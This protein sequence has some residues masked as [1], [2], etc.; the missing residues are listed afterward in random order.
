MS[1]SSVNSRSVPS[2]EV[3][4]FGEV[5][6]RFAFVKLLGLQSTESCRASAEAYLTED[7]LVVDPSEYST[8]W[9]T[10]IRAH[11]IAYDAPCRST[12]RASRQL[13]VEPYICVRGIRSPP[14]VSASFSHTFFLLG[15]HETGQHN[16]SEPAQSSSDMRTRPAIFF[17]R[18]TGHQLRV[19]TDTSVITLGIHPSRRHYSLKISDIAIILPRVDHDQIGKL[20]LQGLSETLTRIP[21][22]QRATCQLEAPPNTELVVRVNLTNGHPEIFKGLVKCCASPFRPSHHS[23]YARTAFACF[24][25]SI[26]AMVAKA[27]CLPCAQKTVHR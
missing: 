25:V 8:L 7:D 17:I 3:E 20:A 21:H 12:V 6:V 1:Q 27:G 11:L 18:H 2:I 10:W 4:I 16:V 23:K 9:L 22:G 15:T 5:I 19:V 13:I 14:A 26:C 24:V